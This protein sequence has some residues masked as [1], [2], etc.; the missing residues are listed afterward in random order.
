MLWNNIDAN[1]QAA[2]KSA[3]R[4]LARKG[5]ESSARGLETAGT[6]GAVS[7]VDYFT[8]EYSGPQEAFAARR[9]MLTEMLRDPT[10][11]P[12]AMAES[13][14][15]LPKTDPKLF[16]ALAGRMARATTYVTQNLPAGIATSL[17]HPRGIPPSSST[18]RDFALV[19]NSAMHPETVIQDVANGTAVPSQIRALQ[20]VDPDTYQNLL[21]SVTEEI[22][23]N[24]EQTSSQTKQWCDI[25]FQ[26]DGIAGPAF[27]WRAAE[28]MT[29]SMQ[30]EKQGKPAQSSTAPLSKTQPPTA[31]GLEAIRS[32][33]TNRGGAS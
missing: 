15:D 24:Y 28:F 3:A 10:V 17:T 20:T 16:E 31:S 33:V 11:L 6:L 19:W 22:G 12:S 25:L 23:Q 8:G 1:G 18:M 7:A 32:G 13:F 21:Q 27:S 4:S 9:E 2:I 30:N 26:S 14:G 29:E 5:L